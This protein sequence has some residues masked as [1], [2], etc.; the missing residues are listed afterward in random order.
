[1]KL[2]L[3]QLAAGLG[4][5]LG[6]ALV[7]AGAQATVIAQS[8][9]KIDGLTMRVANGGEGLSDT[10]FNPDNFTDV[11]GSQTGQAQA[12]LNDGLDLGAGFV[13]NLNSPADLFV[14]A[15]EIH[16]VCEGAGCGGYVSP[17]DLNPL[18]ATSTFAY[19]QTSLTGNMLLGIGA[20]LLLDNTIALVGDN[21]GTA[22]SKIDLGVTFNFTLASG[23][24][25]LEL[26]FSA[27]EIFNQLIDT[28]GEF[29][30]G[31]NSFSFALIKSTDIDPIAE[32]NPTGG[33][34]SGGTVYSSPFNLNRNSKTVNNPMFNSAYNSTSVSSNIFEFETGALSAGIYQLSLGATVNA[35]GGSI[36][37]PATLA[38]LS[39]GLMG[40]GAA[41]RR[42]QA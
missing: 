9:L 3:T 15:N 2:S 35:A 14:V 17:T 13:K 19:A 42:R 16:S 34:T 36:P 6:A 22:Q 1:M 29:A 33:M 32:W 20:N 4:I 7:P 24:S 12:N 8:I 38:L 10:L 39:I 41:A 31:D 27:L 37:E 18:P 11:S 28:L 5:A 26:R 40:V 23:V 30:S 21:D 25:G